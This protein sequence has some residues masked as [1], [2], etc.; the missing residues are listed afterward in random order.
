VQKTVE[1]ASPCLRNAVTMEHSA[2]GRRV[3]AVQPPQW[4]AKKVD[5]HVNQIGR[6]AAGPLRRLQ[7][8][9]S[10]KASCN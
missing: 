5:V 3:V 2:K 8:A 9:E 4:P 1:A 10:S 7:T 6:N